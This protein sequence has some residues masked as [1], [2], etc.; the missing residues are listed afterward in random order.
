MLLNKRIHFV[1]EEK[2]RWR[3]KASLVKYNLS[4]QSLFLWIDKNAKTTSDPWLVV[5]SDY[6]CVM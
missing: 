3:K 2:Y 1:T 4:D 5:M 6:Y